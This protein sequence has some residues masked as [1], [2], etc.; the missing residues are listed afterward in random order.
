MG[1]V[2]ACSN[3][4]RRNIGQHSLTLAHILLAHA[5]EATVHLEIGLDERRTTA[6][7]PQPIHR[8]GLC[9]VTSRKQQQQRFQKR[10]FTELIWPGQ[11]IKG[12][13]EPFHANGL[14]EAADFPQA[15]GANFH[16][17]SLTRRSR[18]IAYSLR[19]AS[20]ASSD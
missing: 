5:P 15:N 10:G 11:H 9:G 1:L 14:R 16:E 12:T 3:A 18:T 4:A 7:R 19:N 2:A 17:D 20:D 13:G 8:L 6:V